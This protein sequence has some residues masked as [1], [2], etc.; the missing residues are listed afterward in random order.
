[1]QSIGFNNS[2]YVIRPPQR[3][4]AIY[5]DP[6]FTG[7]QIFHLRLGCNVGDFSAL[8]LQYDFTVPCKRR[9]SVNSGAWLRRFNDVTGA[10]KTDIFH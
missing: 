2:G 10:A 6:P 5:G 8:Q 9:S 7:H 3:R 4:S 1:M